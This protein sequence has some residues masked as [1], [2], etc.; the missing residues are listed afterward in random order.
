M[1]I[2]L[3]YVKKLTRKITP[4][5]MAFSLRCGMGWISPVMEFQILN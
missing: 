3:K 1:A 2:V 5:M 4:A